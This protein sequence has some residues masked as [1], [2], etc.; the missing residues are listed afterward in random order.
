M[1]VIPWLKEA[2]ELPVSA[3]HT[4]RLQSAI[5]HTVEK[6]RREKRH[7]HNYGDNMQNKAPE[8]IYCAKL[9]AAKRLIISF[10]FEDTTTQREPRTRKRQ[11]TFHSEEY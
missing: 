1:Y 11:V 8:M 7:R 5:S 4:T 9:F 2:S 10:Y 6:R 3:Y